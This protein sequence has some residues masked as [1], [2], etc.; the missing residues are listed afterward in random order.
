MAQGQSTKN[1]LDDSVDSDQYVVSKTLSLS[2]Q[3]GIQHADAFPEAEIRDES[4]R[5]HQVSP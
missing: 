2:L 5:G 4:P 1:P 3:E